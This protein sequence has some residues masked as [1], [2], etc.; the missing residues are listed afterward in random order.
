MNDKIKEWAIIFDREIIEIKKMEKFT[1]ITIYSNIIMIL[2][3]KMLS[4]MTNRKVVS[5]EMTKEYNK[6]EICIL[7]EE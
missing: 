1:L 2:E 3:L 5:V 4:Y 6:M 7:N